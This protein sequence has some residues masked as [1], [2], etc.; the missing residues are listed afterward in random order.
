MCGEV[1]VT[2][3][4]GFIGRHVAAACASVGWQVTGLDNREP[5]AQVRERMSFRVADVSDAITVREV[6]EG[7]FAAVLHHAGVS[8]TL[9]ED[10]ELLRRINVDASLELA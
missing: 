5:P 7:R 1:L 10:W 9:V 8:S 6:R 3:A 4:A 2:G